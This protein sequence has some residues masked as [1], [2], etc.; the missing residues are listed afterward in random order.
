MP[1]ILTTEEEFEVWL[2]A[3]WSEASGRLKSPA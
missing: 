1:A 3:P 2:G